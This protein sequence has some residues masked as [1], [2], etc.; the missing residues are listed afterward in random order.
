MWHERGVTLQSSLPARLGD[1]YEVLG[2]LGRGGMAD[3]YRGRDTAL[4]REVAIKVLRDTAHTDRFRAEART[5]AMLSHPGLVTVLDVGEVDGHPFLVMELVRGTTLADCCLGEPLPPERVA[6]IGTQL[7][8]ALAHVHA[9]GV[10]HR[11]LK[12]ANVLLA[13]DDRVLLADF[14]IARLVQQHAVTETGH[15]MGTAAYLAPEQVKGEPVTPAAD[16][17]ALGLVLL[18]A[19]TGRREYPGTPAESAGARLHRPPQVP[20]ELGDAWHDLL[21][22]MTSASPRDRPDAL[23]VRRQLDAL[24]G[25]VSP[26]DANRALRHDDA[27]RAY[28]VPLTVGTPPAGRRL[29]GAAL[30]WVVPASVLAVLILVTVLVL[31]LVGDDGATPARGEPTPRPTTSLAPEV[32]QRLSELR[33]AVEDR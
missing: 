4:E 15:T 6:A 30:L 28:T 8:A 13:A 31:S 25:G 27:T 26:G 1:R 21:V 14:G 2:P 32:S 9:S 24:S 16:V 20:A 18:E 17:Y 29:S 11:D 22:T 3:V 5:L 10:L 12:P 19:L 7:A 33:D 23:E